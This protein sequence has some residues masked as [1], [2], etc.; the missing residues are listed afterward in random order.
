MLEQKVTLCKVQFGGLDDLWHRTFFGLG[1]VM[2][3]T[4]SKKTFSAVTFKIWDVCTLHVSAVPAIQLKH[5]LIHLLYNVHCTSMKKC[6]RVGI[7]VKSG[8]LLF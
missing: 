8:G 2:A 6:C 4:L 3:L 7:S 5:G 1:S